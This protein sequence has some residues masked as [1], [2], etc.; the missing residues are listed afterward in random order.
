[1][2]YTI[3]ASNSDN[4]RTQGFNGNE[5]NLRYWLNEIRKDFSKAQISTF[6]Y[7]PLIGGISYSS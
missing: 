4:D 5:G 2:N 6:I 1:M 7:K 3:A